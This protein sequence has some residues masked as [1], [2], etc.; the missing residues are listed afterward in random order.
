MKKLLAALHRLLRAV[1]GGRP[2]DEDTMKKLLV[3]SAL[4]YANGAIHLGHL[5]EYIQT[6]IWVRYWRLR[7][8]DVI[9]L[10]ADD[11]HG[12][13]IMMKARDEGISPEQLIDRVGEEHVRDFAGFK[14][15]FDNYY[16]THSEENKR[17]SERIFL[18]LR[19]GGHIAE[20]T[21]EQLYCETD[22][23]FLPDRFV[24]GT[25][26][27]C[28]AEDQYGDACEVCAHTYSPRDL[29]EPYCVTCGTTPTWR[30]SL[31][32]FFRLSDFT[33]R[34]KAWV[35]PEHVQD[36]VANKLQEWF[37]VGL[38]DWDISRDAPY[39]GFEIPGYPGKYFYVWLDAPIGYMAA[40][41]HW[42]ARH[43]GDF[44]AYWRTED[45]EVY[46]FIGKDIVYFHALFWPAMLMGSGHRTPTKL[47]VHGFLTVNGEKMSKTRGTFINAETY[48][49]HL[50]PQYLRYYYATKLNARV[51]DLDLNL[52]DF[53]NRVNADLVNKIANIPSRVLAILH[54]NCG[55]RLAK[56]DEGGRALVAKLRGRCDDIATLYAAREF[57]QVTRL[58]SDLAGE[59]NVY[60][61]EHK[62]W[63]TAKDDASVAAVPCTAALNAYKVLATLIQP[64]LPDFGTKLARVLGAEALTWDG[65][66]D[67]FEDRPVGPYERLVDRVERAKVDAVVAESRET[68]GAEVEPPALTLDP[69]VDVE[70]QTMRAVEVR[71]LE[72]SQKLVA[73]TFEQAGGGRRT[74]VAGLGHDA[75][76]RGLAGQGLLVVAN[77][78]PKVM[79]GQE[80]QGM[81]LAATVDGVP[82][83]VVVPEAQTAAPVE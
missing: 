26:P 32:L 46:H 72:K 28:K 24:K 34:L 74:V 54:K 16:T 12:T 42:C 11:T 77:L 2:R 22:R 3:T 4:P 67:L 76:N 70:L 66:D 8:R 18:A 10:C 65:L 19:D 58:L 82:V 30:E 15:Q 20:R 71:P 68:L 21:V 40:C 43:A 39:F 38:Q 17:H 9:Y 35:N 33:D 51:E 81:L 61:Q 1:F 55:G 75:V 47:C 62:P 14:V 44:D 36:E 6:D 69:L 56:L 13:P 23:M 27:F 78:E 59:V 7:G 80:S 31:H 49:R 64:I 63:Q 5:V 73:V 45:T 48:L 53:V 52:D 29:I 25:C 83:P 79:Q 60:L 41:E 50:D 37:Q 57:G